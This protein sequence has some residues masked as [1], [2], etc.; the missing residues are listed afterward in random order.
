MFFLLLLVLEVLGDSSNC[1]LEWEYILSSSTNPLLPEYYSKMYIYSGF[2]IN[3]LGN[4][5]SCNKIAEAKYVVK[6]YNKSPPLL[7]A[8]CGPK[9][10]TESDYLQLSLPT[11]PP[12]LQ[13][14]YTVVF[15]TEYQESAYSNYTPGAIFMLILISALTALS[16]FASIADYFLSQNSKEILA[17]K[18]VLCF[19]ITSNVQKLLTSRTQE[20]LGKTDTLEIL[21]AVRVMSIGWVVLGHTCINYIFIAATSNYDTLMDILTQPSYI[22]VYGAF[23]AVDTFFW[24]SGLLMAY[25][26]II[27]VNKKNKFTPGNL[28]LFYLH[29]YLR[30]TPV[31]MFCLLFVWTMQVHLGSGPLWFDIESLIGDCEEYWF[32]SLIYLNNFIANW[33]SSSC[34]AVS[35][36][37]ANDMQLFIISPIIILLYTKVSR[38]TGWVLILIL[39]CINVISAGVIAWHYNLNPVLF[40]LSN[41]NNYFDQY[42]S[43]PYNRVG[44]YVL[45]MAC[46]FIIYSHRKYQDTKETYDCFALFIARL[47][48]VWYVRVVSFVLGLGL[49]NILIYSQLSTIQYPGDYNQYDSWSKNQNYAFIAFERPVYGLGLSLMILPML[50]GHF[51]CI[52]RVLS[53]YLWS[54]LARFAF[55]VYLIHF[56]IMQ[57]I[58]K[59]QQNVMMVNDYN[60]IRDTCYFFIVSVVCAMPIVLLIEMP[61]GNLERLIFRRSGLQRL[62]EKEEPLLIKSHESHGVELRNKSELRS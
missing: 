14:P 1:L 42:Y 37:L 28:G 56:P 35:W 19:S 21:N 3:N 2:T 55:V 32:A 43:K 8:L 24:L 7:L 26:F 13:S 50:L 9:V 59:S 20:R 51:K 54:V 44:P 36:Y 22:V 4:F 47:Q 6:V 16:I 15:P 33:E 17:I 23:Y 38:L 53:L 52:S 45:G 41:G 49:I 57:I 12:P 46:G 18:A 48:E 62:K 25:L 58:I 39:C 34:L 5:E 40:A 61:V 30:I 11:I 10:C 27:E 31:F 60:T 29:R